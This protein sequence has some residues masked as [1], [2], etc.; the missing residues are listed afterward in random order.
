MV[1][2]LMLLKVMSYSDSGLEVHRNGDRV[3]VATRGRV[4]AGRNAAVSG[5]RDRRTGRRDGL[6]RSR[7]PDRAEG[8]VGIDVVTEVVG[9][10][11]QRTRRVRRSAVV[12]G[13]LVQHHG[14]VRTIRAGDLNRTVSRAGCGRSIA[15]EAH[16]RAADSARSADAGRYRHGGRS[17]RRLR[18]TRASNHRHREGSCADAQGLRTK[19]V[20]F[21]ISVLLSMATR[22]IHATCNCRF[23]LLV[24]D[25]NAEQREV[26]AC[27]A[28]HRN[29]AA[30]R[31]GR[32]A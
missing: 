11:I 17:R 25:S 23:E 3:V 4:L 8:V 21:H 30:G 15:T 1:F 20:M 32:C 19:S 31:D 5:Q 27:A 28:A 29:T 6:R 2:P 16:G 14:R 24:V 10:V 26:A 9:A 7:V 18:G 22:A 13:A 12:V